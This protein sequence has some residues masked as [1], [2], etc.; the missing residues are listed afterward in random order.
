MTHVDYEYNC[1]IMK[2]ILTK[3]LLWF[4]RFIAIIERFEIQNNS[5]LALELNTTRERHCLFHG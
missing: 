2:I 5:L 1:Y 3:T 4:R